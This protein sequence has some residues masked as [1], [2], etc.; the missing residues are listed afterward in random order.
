MGRKRQG[1]EA[2]DVLA[3]VDDELGHHWWNVVP[4]VLVVLDLLVADWIHVCHV[5]FK[6]CNEFVLRLPIFQ[7]SGVEV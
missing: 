4:L 1:R 2:L 3:Q 5:S 7:G 6:F